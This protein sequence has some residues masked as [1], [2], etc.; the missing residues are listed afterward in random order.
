MLERALWLL[1]K[2]RRAQERYDTIWAPIYDQDWGSRIEASHR[3]VL[4]R[5][6][7][8]FDHPVMILDAGCG[9]G[10]YWPILLERPVTVIGADQSREMLN[11]AQAKHPA[12]PAVQVGLQEIHY[13]GTAQF[14]GVMCMD[15]MEN[16]FP[17]DWPVVLAGFWRVLKPGGYLYFTVELSSAETLR[18]SYDA[19][20]ALGLPVV[21][22]EQAHEDG[23][24]YYPSDSQVRQWLDDARFTPLD[25]TT[26][27]DYWHLICQRAE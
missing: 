9:T 17:E 8:H 10:K 13:L 22:G 25:E 21:P 1:E 4:N 18:A 15:A 2:R 3:A 27:D 6:L 11:R 23:Y 20:V 24:H 16:I 5:F 12:V 7:S 26:G 19:A 14:D